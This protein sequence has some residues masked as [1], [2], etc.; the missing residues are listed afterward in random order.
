MDK[1][2]YEAPQLVRVGTLH[3]LTLTQN[4]IFGSPSDFHYPCKLSFIFS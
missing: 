3:E 1:K 4:K 2:T